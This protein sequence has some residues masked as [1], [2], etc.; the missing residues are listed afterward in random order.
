MAFFR[1]TGKEREG[2]EEEEIDCIFEVTDTRLSCYTN[3]PNCFQQNK[4][5][6]KLRK[7]KHLNLNILIL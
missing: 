3:R 2:K 4:Y 5:I 1:Q 6:K 7:Y